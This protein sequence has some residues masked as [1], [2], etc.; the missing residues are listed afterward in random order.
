MT[1]PHADAPAPDPEPA[2]DDLTPVAL[3]EP[4][5]QVSRRAIG[6][7]LVTALLATAVEVAVGVTI[8][9]L[10]PSRPWWAT[11]LL[12]LLIVVNLA[13]SALMPRIRYRVHRWEVSP[14]AIHTRTGWLTT[15]TRIA[16]LNRVQTVDSQQGPVMRLFR[17]SSITVTT[18]SAAGPITIDGLDQQEAR[19]LVARLT[20]ITA[21]SEGDAT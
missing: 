13:Y 3:R 9:V 6:Y 19:E 15:E 8:Y 17:L 7:W 20:A 16:P 10:V 1:L 12:V 4:A 14:E 21:A 11:A 2:R 5:N 18:A